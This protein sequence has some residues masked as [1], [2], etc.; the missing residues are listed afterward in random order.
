MSEQPPHETSPTG[1]PTP[2]GEMPTI[3]PTPPAEAPR[4]PDTDTVRVPRETAPSARSGWGV[5]GAGTETAPTPPMPPTAPAAAWGAP[6]PE[7]PPTGTGG[8]PVAWVTAT[9]PSRDVPAAPGLVFADTASRLVAYI[10]DGILLLIIAGIV[11]GVGAALAGGDGETMPNRTA[12]NIVSSIVLVVASLLYSVVFWTG[13]RRATPGQM[14]FGIQVGNAFDGQTL[15]PIQAVKRWMG[16]GWF[17]ASLSA[18]PSVANLTG[19]VGLVWYLVL[20]ITT[21]RS[22]VKQGFHDRFANSAVVRPRASSSN[23]PVTACLIGALVLGALAIVSILA[24]IFLGSQVSN[25]L[26]QTGRS[27]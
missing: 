25:I 2:T 13:G 12:T 20:L 10:V 19:V 24:L 14:L 8:P 26:D 27:I 15:T 3:P 17:F 23:G 9:K 4:E 5:P 16:L 7:P 21:V 18:V 1:E 22:P 6:T 11:V